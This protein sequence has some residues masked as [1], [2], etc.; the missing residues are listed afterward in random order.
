MESLEVRKHNRI[1]AESFYRFLESR[2]FVQL[3]QSS[4]KYY[5]VFVC[6]IL[7]ELISGSLVVFTF[8]SPESYL[9]TVGFLCWPLFV[10]FIILSL[11]VTPRFWRAWRKIDV[12]C[13]WV[14]AVIIAQS[15]LYSLLGSK[16]NISKGYVGNAIASLIFMSISFA[17][18][19][20]TMVKYFPFSLYTIYC[21]KLL[22]LYSGVFAVIMYV[23]QETHNTFDGI[24]LVTFLSSLLIFL[25]YLFVVVSDKEKQL[26]NLAK[27]Q[28]QHPSEDVGLD[29]YNTPLLSIDSE[30]LLENP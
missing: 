2:G 14:L 3:K 7:L 23:I 4:R 21:Y 11:F 5:I 1:T 18:H 29:S 25:N 9:I 16:N 6:S 26:R 13:L 27:N 8:L 30:P 22:R 17:G 20:R 12:I 10:C 15:N 19:V 28:I 24:S